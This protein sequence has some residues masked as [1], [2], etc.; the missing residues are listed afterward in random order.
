VSRTKG[1]AR[2]LSSRQ[3]SSQTARRLLSTQATV[4][5]V[6]FLTC[7]HL[8]LVSDRASLIFTFSMCV[9]HMRS[10]NTTSLGPGISISAN[11]AQHS[12]EPRAKLSYYARGRP[13]LHVKYSHADGRGICRCSSFDRNSESHVLQLP[14]RSSRS[15]HELGRIPVSV[16]IPPASHAESDNSVERHSSR[17]HHIPTELARP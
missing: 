15:Y 8:N 13:G 3:T 17:M 9:K 10:Q 1:A 4:P 5:T 2:M 16:G 12:S 11:A 7:L 14:A 6:V